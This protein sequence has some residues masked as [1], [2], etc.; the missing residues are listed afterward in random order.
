MINTQLLQ[1]F[2]VRNL[3]PKE[4]GVK[5]SP[6][7]MTYHPTFEMN[8]ETPSYRLKT[9]TTTDEL[10]EVFELRFQIFLENTEFGQESAD[11][12]DIDQFDHI[13]DHIIILD[14]ETDQVVGTYRVMTNNMTNT[15]YSENEFDLSALK[16]KEGIKMELGRACIH[17]GHRNGHVI[18][19]LWKGIAKYIQLSG[20]Q[21]LFGCSSVK[22][23]HPETAKCLQ[24]FFDR[25]NDSEFINDIHSIGKFKMDLSEEMITEDQ[26]IESK[27]LIPP[28]LKSYLSAGAQ[29]CPS[30][31]LD[32][33]FEC[34]DFLTVLDM[35]NLSRLFKKRYF[36]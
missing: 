33:E 6:R 27:S 14:K 21:Y 2:D 28:L 8:I 7:F 22:T 18:D 29:I 17:H 25:K 5:F 19:L 12:Y 24:E 34:I 10:T 3:I 1:M 9:A 23:T 30:P 31:A 4:W 32:E 20:A 16:A 35:D 26:I 13:C 11:N 36:S 15:F